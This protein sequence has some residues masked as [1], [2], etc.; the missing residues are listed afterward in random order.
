MGYP[1]LKPSEYTSDQNV[2][3]YRADVLFGAAAITSYK[4]KGFTLARL[5][6]GNYRITMEQPY[7]RFIDRPQFAW[8]KAAGTAVLS[9]LVTASAALGTTGTFEITTVTAAGVAT[10]PANGDKA[11][12]T[13][14]LTQDGENNA[15]GG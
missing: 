2:H 11:T 7:L 14:A 4:G 5:G 6:V 10:E 3:K 1:S 13:W 12:L 9:T 15:T 8:E